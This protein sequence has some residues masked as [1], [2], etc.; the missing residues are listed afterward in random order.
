[1]IGNY[2][3]SNLQLQVTSYLSS[4]STQYL[5]ISKTGIP[6]LNSKIRRTNSK[7]ILQTHPDIALKRKL[8]FNA[9]FFPLENKS[10]LKMEKN[11][12]ES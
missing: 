1:M 4:N 5:P 12:V 3:F 10:F 6:F 9:S 7:N 8:T 11:R 2:N